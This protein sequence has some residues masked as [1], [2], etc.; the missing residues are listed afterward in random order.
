[1]IE[2]FTNDLPYKLSDQITIEYNKRL[3]DI[4]YL[5]SGKFDYY[6][7]LRQHLEAVQLLLAFSIF[8][9]RVVTNFES[10]NKFTTRVMSNSTATAVQL[11][12]YELT[13]K[14]I[15]K[16]DK[17]VI[18]FRQLTQRYSIPTYLFEYLE[19]KEFLRKIKRFYDDTMK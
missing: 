15:F 17:V 7:P 2:K 10:A 13:Q 4:K 12:T 18:E 19:T 3:S 6:T 16:I 9:K 14:E 5:T 1:M 8:Y 11:G